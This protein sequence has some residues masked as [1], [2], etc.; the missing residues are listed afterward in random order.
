MVTVFLNGKG[1]EPR[2]DRK[3]KRNHLCWVSWGKERLQTVSES[4]TRSEFK[5]TP[6]GRVVRSE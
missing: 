4:S 2:N 1:E 6:L 5:A 3:V